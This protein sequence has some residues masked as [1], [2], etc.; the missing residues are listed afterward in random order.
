MN[1]HQIKAWIDVV[2]GVITLIATFLV[3][4]WAWVKLV[5]ERGLLPP[6]QMDITVRN[7]GSTEEAI[8]VEVGV[9]IQNRGSSALV[10]TDLRIRLRYLTTDDHIELVADPARS[11]YGRISFL[12]AHAVK[13][14]HSRE[15]SNV[16]K[17]PEI[18]RVSLGSG[19]FLV[20]PYDTFVQPGVNQNYTFATALPSAARY[21]LARA[22]FAYQ[23][24]PSRGQ[25]LVLRF[26]RFM[27]LM[28]Y[29]LHHIREPHT[30]EKSFNLHDSSSASDA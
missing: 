19:E 25:L 28:Q 27:G 29:S 24:H 20:V 6:S 22:S 30:I 14:G 4:L 23:L 5:L 17:Q 8:L 10:V 11:S 12:R 15:D 7:I 26:G 2:Q 9:N 16:K 21:L 3:G 13:N 1:P 18:Q